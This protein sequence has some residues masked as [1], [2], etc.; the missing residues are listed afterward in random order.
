[1]ICTGE[2]GSVGRSISAVASSTPLYLIVS[3][4]SLSGCAA[5]TASGTLMSS[6]RSG[7][8]IPTTF[9]RASYERDVTS[10]SG[11]APG[12]CLTSATG[13]PAPSSSYTV[14]NAAPAPF[15]S[16]STGVPRGSVRRISRSRPS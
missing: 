3:R 10:V 13:R 8:L 14:V 15:V 4:G 5:T 2:F 1:L 6:L 11:S 7:S 9:P 16:S 12:A